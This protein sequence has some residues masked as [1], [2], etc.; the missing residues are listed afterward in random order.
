VNEDQARSVGL[1]NADIA[2][3][4]RM[5]FSGATVTLMREGEKEIPVQL[6]FDASERSNPQ[7]LADMYLPTATGQ[8]VPLRQV[9]S[10]SLA[11]QEGKIVRRNHV[12]TLTVSAFT[13]GNRLASKILSEA[14]KRIARTTLPAGVEVGYGGEQ[15]EVGK[16]FTE[17]LLILGFTVAANLV[18]VVW[19]FNSFRAALTVLV[20]I[21]FSMI[22]A[23]L[24]LWV[25]HLPFGFM[26]FLGIVSL[27]GVVTNHA[28]VLF[29]Y[30]LAE[31]RD[32]I[33]MDQALLRAGRRR[34]RPILLTV[35]LSI[36]GVLPQGLNGGTLW[37]PL[38]WSLIFGLLM[39]LVLTLV[40]IPSFY[41][42]ISRRSGP[43][44]LDQ[45]P[46][47]AI[48]QDPT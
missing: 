21:P 37:P 29:E 45:R 3:A 46:G 10:L 14:Q 7:S 11:P 2:D 35:L 44:V 43:P 30:A 26:A 28:I 22:G 6:R 31:L 12:R 25:M 42:L 38:A 20:A 8:A 5:G 24:G 39:S 9:A 27:S 40:V 41:K 4:T 13:T 33:S 18:I 15:E 16:S 17:L 34:L 23:I 36:F 32:G 48:S 47:S 19:E 1:T